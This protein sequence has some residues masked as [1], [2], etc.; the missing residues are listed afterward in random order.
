MR[1][2]A[3]LLDADLFMRWFKNNHVQLTNAAANMKRFVTLDEITQQFLLL[4]PARMMQFLV[5]EIMR[6]KNLLKIL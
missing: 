6:L 2:K 5:V 3:D 4:E 1:T